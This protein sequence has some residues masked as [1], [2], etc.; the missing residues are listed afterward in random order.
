MTLD[1]VFGL[2]VIATIVLVLVMTLLI[3]F[4]A[5]GWFPKVK[6]SRIGLIQPVPAKK[7][8]PNWGNR[9]R[10]CGGVIQAQERCPSCGL[11]AKEALDKNLLNYLSAS[12]G[13][14]SRSQ[15]ASEL[16]T[17]PAD[18]NASLERLIAGG[19]IFALPEESKGA[20]T[21]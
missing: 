2:Y 9:C 11:T 16:R 20:Y 8:R 13:L 21:V 18:L 5:R 17:S 10:S 4:A 7:I 6:L 15:A 12:D 1:F 3:A 19:K 14:L